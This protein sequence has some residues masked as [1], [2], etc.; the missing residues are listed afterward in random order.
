MPVRVITAEV[1]GQVQRITAE[2]PDGATDEDIV[3]VVQASLGGQQQPETTAWGQA[4][5]FVKGALDA[6]PRGVN[7]MTRGVKALPFSD[8]VVADALIQAMPGGMGLK[9][10]AEAANAYK[11]SAAERFLAP[12]PGYEQST[13]RGV[14]SVVGGS[15]PYLASALL[16]PAAV[17]TM[18][19]MG[20]AQGAGGQGENID[21][22]RAQGKQISGTE[23]A[24]AEL[25]GAG[26]G[27]GQAAVL[28][29]M[30]PSV[31]RMLG[32]GSEAVTARTAGEVAKS[33]LAQT[34]LQGAAG[35]A[36]QAVS[37]LA[38][39]GIYNPEKDL[40][41]NVGEAA[42]TNA[43]GGGLMD[44]VIGLMARRAENRALA[45]QQQA[46]ESPATE[47]APAKVKGPKT[48]GRKPELTLEDLKAQ[49]A[50]ALEENAVLK[51]EQEP[52]TTQAPQRTIVPS[53][54]PEGAATS[55][56]VGAESLSSVNSRTQP[57]PVSIE[58]PQGIP[59]GLNAALGGKNPS[60][61]IG[62]HNPE[63]RASE[64]VQMDSGTPQ[65]R[66]QIE[67]P[68]QPQA[69]AIKQGESP[70]GTQ[71]II[72]DAAVGAKQAEGQTPASGV[73]VG[74]GIPEAVI[75]PA[76]Q[77]LLDVVQPSIGDG[78]PK[79][80]AKLREESGLGP[81]E[82]D[83]AFRS[84]VKQD[85]IQS[86]RGD[87]PAVEMV[88]D[89]RVEEG[90]YVLAQDGRPYLS[91]SRMD[92]PAPQQKSVVLGSGLGALQEFLEPKEPMNTMKLHPNT[93]SASVKLTEDNPIFSP[94]V[95]KP[96]MGR[97]ILDIVTKSKERKEALT[98]FRQAVFDQRARIAESDRLTA[99]SDAD[100]FAD[101]AAHAAA[102]M[103]DRSGNVAVPAL[104]N[105]GMLY[106]DGFF[107]VSPTD[108][109]GK[110][111]EGLLKI[112]QPL[113]DNGTL[114]N[115]FHY[116]A[117]IRGEALMPSGKEHKLTSQ[118][119]AAYK[120]YARQFPEIKTASAKFKAWNDTFVDA[121]A[122]SGRIS[123]AT[124]ADWK[125]RPYLP[126]Y[127]IANDLATGPGTHHQPGGSKTLHQIKGGT[128][129]IA[130]PLENVVRNM[131]ALTDIAMKNVAAQRAI[132]NSLKL[133]WA[134]AATTDDANT[135]TVYRNGEKFRYAVDDKLMFDAMTA[136][137]LPLPKLVEFFRIPAQM[138]RK[139]VTINPAFMVKN[140]SRDTLDIY[141][142]GGFDLVPFAST[143]DGVKQALTE[144]PHFKALE[145]AGVVGGNLLEPGAQGTRMKV[146]RK[147]RESAGE[148]NYARQMIDKLYEW[149]EKSEA[150]NRIKVYEDSL[151]QHGNEAQAVFEALEVMNF[152]RRGNSSMMRMA[153]AMI[154]F[155]NARLQGLDLL[156][157]HVAGHPYGLD[158]GKGGRGAKVRKQM[159]MRGMFM[160]M[161]T[162]IY[163][164]AV[165]GNKAWQNATPQERDDNWFLPLG[166]DD[167]A[168]IKIPIP[169][170]LGFMW[171]TIP[172][173]LFALTMGLDRA[174]QT[175]DALIRGA[176]N[177]LMQPVIPQAVKP[178]AENM[179]NY[180]QFRGAPIENAAQKQLLPEERWDEYTSQL[181]RRI[182]ETT[183]QSPLMVDN[184]L[185]GYLGTVGQFGLQFADSLMRPE[186]QGE[187]ADYAIWNTP[188]VGSFFQRPDAAGKILDFY[189][190][191]EKVDEAAKSYKQA[192]Q[193]GDHK[194]AKEYGEKY[195]G[196]MAVQPQV[197]RI[198]REMSA[199]TKKDRLI[200]N[201]PK[202]TGEQ[203]RKMS[204][205]IRKRKIALAAKALELRKEVTK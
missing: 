144:S 31:A 36:G 188:V 142:K 105:G 169:F 67:S 6:I 173:R 176:K 148:R 179:T 205:E 143:V 171:K 164:M 94:P 89:G 11:D 133:G 163:T 13:P 59:S 19:A 64:V 5:E 38:E 2:V 121:L 42:I 120:D 90:N 201:S 30:A 199:L 177:N 189:E 195:R 9:G 28:G 181:A 16:G 65:D 82:F 8:S 147:M 81:Q 134:R 98:A 161:G 47:V 17:P 76:E 22:L 129:M 137:D 190:F 204:D 117:A 110:P 118:Q 14:G 138:L 109:G 29:R 170:E 44:G 45:Q 106:K 197:D 99:T 15:V 85:K 35:G 70:N 104:T 62:A 68:S 180:S 115:F 107:Q 154:P 196:E 1:N 167:E 108:K 20:A 21:A 159:L 53:D 55:A 124:A 140:L 146:E 157:R 153:T 172:E 69:T 175:K 37:N 23:E 87:Q 78:P 130:D 33:L 96:G 158:A 116:Q 80:I 149:S 123:K 41:E 57:D 162:A 192:M 126:F 113:V 178:I 51:G 54:A 185:R 91:A 100:L 72:N 75:T 136:A 12:A 40:M 119:I 24:L 125:S 101:K 48:R 203:K 198:G 3:R 152:S 128:E 155:L 58:V 46:V 95:K 183:G 114:A 127:R 139:L 135:V 66:S 186:S 131:M 97:Q 150:A 77:K 84:L 184:L 79:T 49:L 194:K 191:R 112:F 93:D 4:K 103:A 168:P 182:G 88:K 52:S 122:D 73:N 92:E 50:A 141:L 63:I 34:A 174:D 25:A 74:E 10:I 43:L 102:L 7:T 145:N 151:K 165:S 132:D 86:N 27:A 200:L 202:L 111:V 32:I 71:Q 61:E 187:K 166:D 83:D 18:M 39:K 193:F 60:H 160:A 26:I 156:G 56:P